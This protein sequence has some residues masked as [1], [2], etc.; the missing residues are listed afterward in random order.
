MEGKATQ[1]PGTVEALRQR[2]AQELVLLLEAERQIEQR[3]ADML[4]QTHGAAERR[5]LEKVFRVERLHAQERIQ[6]VVD[7]N[8]A[9][10]AAKQRGS[11][12]AEQRGSGAAEQRA[13]KLAR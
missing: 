11:G 2:Q 6:L 9:L 7:D 13:G 4:A 5:R 3:R 8:A 10:L 12:A 1:A